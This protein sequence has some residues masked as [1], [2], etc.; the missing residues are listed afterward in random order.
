M[1]LRGRQAIAAT[2][3]SVAE[4]GQQRVG[5]D[6]RRLDA[7]AHPI[8]QIELGREQVASQAPDRVIRLGAAAVGVMKDGIRCVERVDDVGAKR[9]R[10][11]R[12]GHTGRL[13]Q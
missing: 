4:R 3:T 8:R 13:L 11:Q 5:G 9:L 12:L 6:D 7:G 1:A 10:E 2:R